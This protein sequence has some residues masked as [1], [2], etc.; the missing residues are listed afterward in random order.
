MKNGIQ[1]NKVVTSLLLALLVSFISLVP[2]GPVENR[3]FSHLPALVFWGFNA[4]LIALGLTGFITT[5]FVWKNR[6]WAFWSAI[7]IGWLYI[8]VV[9]S[10][11]GKVFPTSPDQTGFALGLIMIFDAIFAFNIILFS[12]KNLG[13]I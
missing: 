10:D 7:L 1:Y 12:H 3:D 6:P 5:Y 4:F 13:H 9:A 8:V 11:L 2:G